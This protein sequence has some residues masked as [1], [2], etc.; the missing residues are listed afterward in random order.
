MIFITDLN[1]QEKKKLKFGAPNLPGK[2]KE[3]PVFVIKLIFS[4]GEQ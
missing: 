1:V 4:V 3:D 2:A